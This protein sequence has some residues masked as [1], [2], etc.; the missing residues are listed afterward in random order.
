MLAATTAAPDPGEAT[1][2]PAA[3]QVSLHR[4]V[5]RRPQGPAA[6]FESLLVGPHVLLEVTLEDPVEPRALRMAGTIDRYFFADSPMSR[7]RRVRVETRVAVALHER[8]LEPPG[9]L[10]GA[11]GNGHPDWRRP[12]KVS[13]WLQLQ[14]ATHGRPPSGGRTLIP[15]TWPESQA[16]SGQ[17]RPSKPCNPRGK[18][19]EHRWCQGGGDTLSRHPG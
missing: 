5:H 4:P 2:E 17:S 8:R 12:G 19:H 16:G 6:M 14:C 15:S 18:H 10:G 11:R 7:K 3:V 9:P 13:S 1:E